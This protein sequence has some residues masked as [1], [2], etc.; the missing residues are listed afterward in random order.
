MT[1]IRLQRL[2]KMLCPGAIIMQVTGCFPISDL[3]EIAQTV[4]L[5]ISAAG[6]LA[7]LDNL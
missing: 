2:A 5:G 7:I 6:A 3:F 1:L 4:F